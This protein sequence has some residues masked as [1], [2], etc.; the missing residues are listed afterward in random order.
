[1]RTIVVLQTVDFIE[2]VASSRLRDNG[3]NILE[4]KQARS[5][6]PSQIKHVSDVVVR[7]RSFDIERDYRS[8]PLVE[9]MHEG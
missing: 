8:L 3:V 1:M 5:H 2:E 6:P 7:T 4:D 9:H